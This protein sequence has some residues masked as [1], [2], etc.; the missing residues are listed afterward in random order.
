MVDSYLSC[1]VF[2]LLLNVQFTTS[3]T[4][5]DFFPFGSEHEDSQLIPGD[6]RVDSVLLD[7]PFFGKMYNSIGV[8]V[9]MVTSDR[10]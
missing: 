4:I 5:E 8:R 7:F 2:V 10:F 9:S 3:L 6:D 1:F